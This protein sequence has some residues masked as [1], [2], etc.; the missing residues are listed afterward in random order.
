MVQIGYDPIPLVFQTNASTK[1]ASA[2][3]EN[4]IGIEPMLCMF[5]RHKPIPSLATRSL[6]RTKGIE[7]FR[8]VLETF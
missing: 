3:I 1:L 4:G 8:K 6:A 2:P 5:C 7:P